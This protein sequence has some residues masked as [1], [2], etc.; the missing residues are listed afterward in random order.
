MSFVEDFFLFF[1]L[2]FV[3]RIG[4]K[5]SREPFYDRLYRSGLDIVMLKN[6]HCCFGSSAAAMGLRLACSGIT[7]INTHLISTEYWRQ[8]PSPDR[9]LGSCRV[10]DHTLKFTS[11]LRI[12][13]FVISIYLFH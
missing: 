4:E 12:G 5:G 9:W 2:S 7:K 8:I 10:V 1:S 11:A 6:H 3:R 13:G